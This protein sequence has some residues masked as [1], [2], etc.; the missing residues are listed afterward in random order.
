M[1]KLGIKRVIRTTEDIDR[2]YYDVAG[3]TES[4]AVDADGIPVVTVTPTT[5]KKYT[6]TQ[7]AKQIGVI[8]EDTM[9]ALYKAHKVYYDELT[10]AESPIF[11]LAHSYVAEF[12]TYRGDLKAAY[13]QIKTDVNDIRN[14]GETDDVK[15]QQII[16]YDWRVQ[17]PAEPNQA[18]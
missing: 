16:D 1:L 17:L 7:L 11:D 14:S 8:I 13:N 4:E 12:E 3:E 9:R 15:Y 6:V 5:S 10:D 2:R 18:A